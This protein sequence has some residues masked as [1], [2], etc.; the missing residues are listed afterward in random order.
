MLLVIKHVTECYYL[1]VKSSITC[2]QYRRMNFTQFSDCFL[3]ILLI[4]KTIK[5]KIRVRNMRQIFY[6]SIYRSRI[7]LSMI[8][9]KK[10]ILLFHSHLIRIKRLERDVYIHIYIVIYKLA[11]NATIN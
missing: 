6:R 7:V 5:T 11:G 1:R 4:F 10:F 2:T 9:G 8:T 3:N